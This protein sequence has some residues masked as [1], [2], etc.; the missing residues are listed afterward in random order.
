MMAVAAVWATV[1]GVGLDVGTSVAVAS[2]FGADLEVRIT[3]VRSAKGVLRVALYDDA[4]DFPKDDV[5]ARVVPARADVTIVRFNGIGP[6]VYAIAAYHDENDN[7]EFDSGFL[8][9]PKEAYGFSNDARPFLS[10]PPFER[11]AF[12]V[13]TGGAMIEFELVYP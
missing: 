13:G 5:Q 4:N 8:G 6:G 3:G 7:N 11:A 10:A 9:L 1:L 2:A 12:E